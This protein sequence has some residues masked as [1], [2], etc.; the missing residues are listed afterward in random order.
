LSLLT[1]ALYLL[2]PLARLR[3]RLGH[4][5]TPWRRRGTHRF[6]LPVR[7]THSFWSERWQSTEDRVRALGAALGGEGAVVRAGG[8]WD[9]WD[10][11]VRGGLFGAARLRIGIE[12]HGGGRQ[13]I[14]VRSWP[15]A[16]PI[17]LLFTILTATLALLA[18]FADGDSV[19]IP[20]LVAAAALVGRTL[21]ECGGATVTI[22]RAL[23]A[24]AAAAAEAE[25]DAEAEHERDPLALGA[26]LGA[27]T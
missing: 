24:P 21:Y 26:P 2:Q 25:H 3:G 5:L 7:R 1:G 12:E 17:S 6:G 11:Q 15:C 19:T 18:V 9:R 27:E 16:P 4:G 20:L 8:D 10:L 23:Y 13:L 22:K 14:R